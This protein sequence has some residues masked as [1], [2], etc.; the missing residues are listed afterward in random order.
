MSWGRGRRGVAEGCAPSGPGPRG[1][2]GRGPEGA[3]APR[4]VARCSRELAAVGDLWFPGTTSAEPRPL[5]PKRVPRGLRIVPVCDPG[6]PAGLR[7]SAP[8][9]S[10]AEGLDRVLVFSGPLTHGSRIPR[11]SAP[12]SPPPSPPPPAPLGLRTLGPRPCR[13]PPGGGRE[14]ASLPASTPTPLVKPHFEDSNYL[15]SLNGSN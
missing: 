9:V 7:F 4:G 11:V 2:R 10:R 6:G 14:L 13:C 15:Q 1:A 8:G 5:S 12:L 3:R